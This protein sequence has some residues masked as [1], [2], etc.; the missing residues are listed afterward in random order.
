MRNDEPIMLDVILLNSYFTFR[1]GVA[2]HND[3]NETLKVN[4]MYFGWVNFS[5]ALNTAAYIYALSV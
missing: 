3:F 4:V 1:R 2:L 5:T